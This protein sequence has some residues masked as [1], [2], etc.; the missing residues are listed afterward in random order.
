MI[1]TKGLASAMS[2]YV[3]CIVKESRLVR[4]GLGHVIALLK[5]CVWLTM[6]VNTVLAR[7]LFGLKILHS[8]HF[9]CFKWMLFEV[10][11]TSRIVTKHNLAINRQGIM[12]WSLVNF[13]FPLL[14]VTY[15]SS[16]V[17]F[18][19]VLLHFHPHP[20]PLFFS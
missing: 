10:T 2:S 9:S 20:L 13:L 16:C 7:V 4:C 8:K 18:N 19:S 17:W 5:P 1:F 14:W 3:P 11:K 12:P 15:L 6:G